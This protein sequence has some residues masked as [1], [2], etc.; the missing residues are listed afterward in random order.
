MN[1]FCDANAFPEITIGEGG[2]K[3][4]E[5]IKHIYQDDSPI[6]NTLSP[7][8]YRIYE[9]DAL[10]PYDWKMVINIRDKGLRDGLIGSVE[11]DIE[12]RLIGEP[13]LKER[14]GYMVKLKLCDAEKQYLKFEYSAAAESRKKFLNS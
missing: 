9:L 1:A 8:F 5:L 7:E 14:I 12:D 10:L 3:S 13:T 4:N 2:G 11:I 6:Q